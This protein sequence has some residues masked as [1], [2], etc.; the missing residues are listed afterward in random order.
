MKMEHY[1]PTISGAAILVQFKM[2]LESSKFFV[3]ML[4]VMIVT[5][6]DP[7]FELTE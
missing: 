4:A 3:I 5:I 6:I 2:S 7:D 1:S